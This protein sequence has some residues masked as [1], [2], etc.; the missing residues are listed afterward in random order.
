[1]KV[2]STS[3]MRELDKRTI[4]DYQVPGEVL[5]DRAGLGVA[6]AV[7]LLFDHYE[8]EPLSVLIIVGRGNNGGDGFVAARYL[9]EQGYDV[10]VWLAGSADEISGDALT[11]LNRMRAA[12]VPLEELSTKKAWDD[13]VKQYHSQISAVDAQV[14]VDGVL[15]T[16]IK[17][18]AHGP[19]GG[20]IRY[21][22]MMGKECYVV[23]IDVPSGMNSDTGQAEG[24]AVVADV[25]LTMG[26]PKR[27]LIEPA[28]T[29]R[30]GHL[31]IIDIGIPMSLVEQMDSEIELITDFD[32]RLL[33]PRRKRNSH[34]GTYGHILMI[35]GAAGYAG[36][37]AMAARAA[38]RSGVGLVTAVVP[39]GISSMVSTAVLEAMIHGAGETES[40][41]L[42]S[43]CWAPWRDR[44]DEFSAVLVG[45]GLTRHDESRLLVRQILKD[46]PVPLIMDADALNVIE[47]GLDELRCLR[48]AGC[49][50][51]ITP[52]PGEMGRLMKCSAG[53]VQSTRFTA[54]VESAEKAHAVVVLKGAGTLVAEQGQ[55]LNINMTGNPGMATGG[56][57]DV[58][59]GLL[60]GLL[61]QG[62][63]PFD[64]A[65]TAVYIHGQAGD[66]AA[67]EN[68]EYCL[69]AG[70]VIDSLPYAFQRV[71]R[72]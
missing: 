48:R 59:S 26:L 46:C 20:A 30:I 65:R 1:M 69:T 22:N 24:D 13:V 67:Y 52:H 12:H 43:D 27:G 62:M 32:L 45:P 4:E 28:A 18:P 68:T 5:M 33:L 2:V 57:G 39:R 15:G 66:E 35:G 25:T 44:L 42:V 37:I 7:D 64:A 60:A 49:S 14:I 21:I 72:Q 55:A 3:Q 70:D 9:R 10:K 63:K 38:T 23:S 11:H 41:S 71:T 53:E 54:A 56:M 36:A 47:G 51:I 19:A 17:G 31:D 58:L 6:L 40:G 8:L 50:L 34:K 29:D 61:A 16:G